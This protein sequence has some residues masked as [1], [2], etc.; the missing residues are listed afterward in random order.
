MRKLLG[1]AVFSSAII[2]G[3]LGTESDDKSEVS[4][5]PDGF[6]VPVIGRISNLFKVNVGKPIN[7]VLRAIT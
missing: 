4:N 3:Y 5:L 7:L 6:S 1:I 2:I